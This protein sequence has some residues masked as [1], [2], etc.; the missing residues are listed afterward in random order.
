[1]FFSLDFILTTIET[2]VDLI[3]RIGVTNRNETRGPTTMKKFGPKSL[4]FRC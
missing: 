3:V 4:N 1:M 2:T